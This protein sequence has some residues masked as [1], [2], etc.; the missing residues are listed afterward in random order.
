[1]S[2]TP[3]HSQTHLLSPPISRG[4]YSTFMVKRFFSFV[5][6]NVMPLWLCL[7]LVAI[8][9]I[10]P[11]SS[12][13]LGWWDSQSFYTLPPTPQA[14]LSSE[15]PVDSRRGEEEGSWTL[16]VP[17]YLLMWGLL[18]GWW[19]NT[20]RIEL[21]LQQL[22]LKRQKWEEGQGRLRDQWPGRSVQ[23]G[24]YFMA[25]LW[26]RA[27]WPSGDLANPTTEVPSSS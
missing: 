17:G 24:G 26:P 18:G 13:L 23:L 2:E 15:R 5:R 8:A 21:Q 1:M 16:P 11:S 10:C 22:A 9:L 12:L 7:T 4:D 6:V 3:W 14:L 27:G 25:H 20:I 19:S